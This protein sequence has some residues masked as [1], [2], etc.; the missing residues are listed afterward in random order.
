MKK[1]A[2]SGTRLSHTRET[3]S[4]ALREEFR[5]KR[6]LSADWIPNRKPIAHLVALALGAGLAHPAAAQIVP[7]GRTATTVTANGVVTDVHTATTRG[8]NAFNAFSQFVVN[9]G[10]IANLHLPAG[11]QNLINLV[12]SKAQIHGTLNSLYASGK[13][14]GNVF[15]ASPQGFVVGEGGVVNV[16]KLTV[17][18]PTAA[19]MNQLIDAG[20]N[21]SDAAVD[22]LLSGNAPQSPEGLITIRGKVNA[23]GGIALQGAQVT[24]DAGAHL[25]SGDAAAA[26]I[27]VN[28]GDGAEVE[29]VESGGA[30]HIVSKGDIDIAGSLRADGVGG[31]SSGGILVTAQNDVRLSGARLDATASGEDADGGGILVWG[32][33]NARAE[34]TVLVSRG[35]GQGG[36]RLHRA[37]C[38]QAGDGPQHH[39][40][41]RFGA[42][43][44]RAFPHRS[45]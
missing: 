16:G 45:R 44:A 35:R 20:G 5:R 11:T 1:N 32:D 27:A 43:T 42:R 41:Y 37:Q 13:I 38:G 25:V 34:D 6:C 3:R 14:G 21:I 31:G 12:D 8:V 36:G 4:H 15:F 24:V 2:H 26:A 17:S 39:R 10:H 40:R 29:M 22:R 18:T 33:R 30:I 9:N 28:L 23:P 7:N 19:F